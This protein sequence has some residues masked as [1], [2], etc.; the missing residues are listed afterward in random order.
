MTLRIRR[1]ALLVITLT[2]AACASISQPVSNLPFVDEFD[3]PASGWET[4]NDLSADVQYE[5][6]Y[7]RILIKQERLTQWTVAGRRF[8]DGVLEVDTRVLGGPMDNGFG[9]LFRAVDRKNFYHFAISS[10][11]YWRA[12]IMK[13]GEWQNWDDWQP[14]P[15]I[16]V[17]NETNRIRV[18]MRG[19]RFTFFVNDQ[20]V[21]SYSDT[22]FSEGDI[23]LLAISM[24]DAP[25]VDVA[26]D[27]VSV[28]PLP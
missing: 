23:G 24:I 15:A 8:R 9:V 20:L 18:E 17:G 1:V 28:Q 27:R 5:N 13:D 22:S 7:L 16:R 2:L 11:G 10:D 19:E 25:G 12:G 4:A 3:N 21:G 6:G 14:H 26:F